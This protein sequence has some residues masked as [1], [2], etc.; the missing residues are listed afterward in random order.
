MPGLKLILVSSRGLWSLAD[1]ILVQVGR[2]YSMLVCQWYT[3]GPYDVYL[4]MIGHTQD[5]PVFIHLGHC[6]FRI[7]RTS[8]CLYTKDLAVFTYEIPYGLYTLKTLCVYI[9]RALRCIHIWDLMV[10]AYRLPYGVHILRNLRRLHTC[11][12]DLA[13]L[14]TR[15]VTVIT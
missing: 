1:I 5:L 3:P 6:G 9:L 7:I 4:Q 8:W 11:T 15:D 14:N 2:L 10:F 13:V 12:K